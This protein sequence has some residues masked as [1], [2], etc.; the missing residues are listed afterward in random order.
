M[1][2][3]TH[4]HDEPYR[5]DRS[6][7]LVHFTSG[8][9][10]VAEDADNPTAE[11][12]AMSA[13]EKLVSI[14]NR[15]R[16]VASTLPWVGRRAA[17][18]TEC[19]WPSLVAH[20]DRYSPFG[21]GF[22]K[23]HVFAAGGSPVYYVRADHWEMQDWDARVKAFVSPFWPSYRPAQLRTNQHLGGS[24]VDYSHERE[25]RIPH[26]FTF[27]Y[28]QVGFVVVSNYEDM[29]AFPRELKDQIGREKFIITE[30]YRAIERLWPVHNL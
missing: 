26:D 22:T 30:V 12:G 20:A 5:P 6:D 23:P 10:P 27:E 16:I 7:Y 18:F 9:P 28:N 3:A 8:R 17:C 21:I 1:H 11:F 29:A 24:T 25:W 15:K 19:P 14:L 4:M 2:G 13:S